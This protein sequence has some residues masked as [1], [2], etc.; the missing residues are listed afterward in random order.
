MATGTR[1]QVRLLPTV[2]NKSRLISAAVYSCSVIIAQRRHHVL[3]TQHAPEAH[4]SCPDGACRSQIPAQRD[5]RKAPLRTA[6]FLS[7]RTSLN[8]T[9]WQ[10]P[11]YNRRKKEQLVSG[12]ISDAISGAI[13]DAISGAISGAITGA[14]SGAQRST[15]RCIRSESRVTWCLQWLWNSQPLTHLSATYIPQGSV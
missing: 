10:R 1:T 9:R 11:M 3:E 4:D 12:A 2:N 6:S 7:P 15:N 8:T 13:S 14:I 5:R